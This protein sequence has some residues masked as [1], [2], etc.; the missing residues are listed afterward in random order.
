MLSILSKQSCV[1][2]S[3]SAFVPLAEVDKANRTLRIH[4][5]S[6]WSLLLHPQ[7]AFNTTPAPLHK[8]GFAMSHDCLAM[9]GRPQAEAGL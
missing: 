8:H 4:R 7:L 2:D 1:G 3:I 5:V 9:A 6:V